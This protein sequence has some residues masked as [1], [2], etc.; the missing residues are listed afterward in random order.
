LTVKT[1]VTIGWLTSSLC[2]L[3][4]PKRYISGSIKIGIKSKT[5]GLAPEMVLLS[6]NLSAAAGGTN[7][8][9]VFCRYK[10]YRH[11]SAFSFVS[12]KR[13]EFTKGPS[14]MVPPLDFSDSGSR[15]NMFKIFENKRSVFFFSNLYKFLAERMV[16]RL[17]K[18]SYS[19]SGFFKMPFGRTCSFFLEL[20]SEIIKA[21]FSS[22]ECTSFK[23]KIIGSYSKPAN[24]EIDA[25][26]FAVN[27][28]RRSLSFKTQ[29]EVK[30]T[31]F[32]IV[33][34]VRLCWCPEPILDFF[35]KFSF[36]AGYCSLNTSC[37]TGKR[38]IRPGK[39]EIT[40]I[41]KAY[42]SIWPEINRCFNLSFTG[43]YGLDCLPDSSY[44]KLRRK[45]KASADIVVTLMVKVITANNILFM[46]SP[47]KVVAGVGVF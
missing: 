37:K 32:G 35:R 31:R 20:R 26:S 6:G 44:R 23:E 7:M 39:T 14:H 24:A 10:M 36:S 8:R 17:L 30:V 18:I 38:N 12:A 45:F 33:N 28:N 15:S 43:F 2:A 29:A 1:H 5:T 34:N 3:D 19:F 13:L 40:W 25:Y 27:R 11:P 9:S 46:R 42:R 41:I 21:V 47:Y 4:I 16:Y 22:K